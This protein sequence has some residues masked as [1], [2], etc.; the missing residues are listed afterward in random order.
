[1]AGLSYMFTVNDVNQTFSIQSGA[2][3]AAFGGYQAHNVILSLAY[4]F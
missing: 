3:S 4:Q 2:G 1:M